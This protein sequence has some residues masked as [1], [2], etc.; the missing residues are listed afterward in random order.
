MAAVLVAAAWEALEASEEVASEEAPCSAI[1]MAVRVALQVAASAALVL[2]AQV[3]LAASAAR[4]WEALVALA[5]LGAV[6]FETCQ[7]AGCL[8]V[9]HGCLRVAIGNKGGMYGSY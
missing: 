4:V 3:A 5:A 8:I 7:F 6:R 9:K 2:A 1:L